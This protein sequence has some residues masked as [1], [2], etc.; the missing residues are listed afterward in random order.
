MPCTLVC[1][2][3]KLELRIDF[4]GTTIVELHENVH[5]VGIYTY[6]YIG[7][8]TWAVTGGELAPPL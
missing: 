6:T 8:V 5:Q 2:S 7:V 4:G 3:T 1:N